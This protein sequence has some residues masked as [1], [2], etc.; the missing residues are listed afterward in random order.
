MGTKEKE[1]N[2]ILG[3]SFH[4]IFL[5]FD[6]QN[7]VKLSGQNTI[8]DHLYFAGWLPY[9]N[10]PKPPN[11]ILPFSWAIA[12]KSTIACIKNDSF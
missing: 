9:F 3:S 2:I 10:T 8:T 11:V 6:F 1:I 5:M 4:N 7:L 12:R